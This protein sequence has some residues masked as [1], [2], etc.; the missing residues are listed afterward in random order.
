MLL[1]FSCSISFLV[2][3]IVVIF[4]IDAVFV[5]G[6]VTSSCCRF[7]LLSLINKS[8]SSSSSY[9]RILFYCVI[10]S[11][12]NTKDK[13]AQVVVNNY[14][15]YT[16]SDTDIFTC[17]D[18]STMLISLTISA[19]LH[20]ISNKQQSK[21]KQISE[22]KSQKDRILTGS[23]TIWMFTSWHKTLVPTLCSLLNMSV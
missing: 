1:F 18:R 6:V 9:C 21:M 7:K 19:Y 13:T 3:V 11:F 8:W 20:Y 22:E 5:T 15:H 17:P 10:A 12:Y 23:K 4:D 16:V 14:W 2:V